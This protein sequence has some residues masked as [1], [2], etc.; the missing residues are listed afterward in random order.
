M[1]AHLRP[2][3]GRRHFVAGFQ[4]L[5]D[6]SYKTHFE[7]GTNIREVWKHIIRDPAPTWRGMREA[8]GPVVHF[9][10]FALALQISNAGV[11]RQFA[12]LR[13]INTSNRARLGSDT[14][15]VEF[16]LR[17]S[18]HHHTRYAAMRKAAV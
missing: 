10:E 17:A 9:A 5:H 16:G 4:A 14:L 11:E 18:G 8:L 6:K 12:H 15:M 2:W 13:L 3:L 1:E 7:E